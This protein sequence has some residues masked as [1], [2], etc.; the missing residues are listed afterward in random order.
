[1]KSK[2]IPMRIVLYKHKMKSEVLK[3]MNYLDKQKIISNSINVIDMLASPVT[4]ERIGRT[5]QTVIAELLLDG[6]LSSINW[7]SK[8][9]LKEMNSLQGV[10]MLEKLVGAKIYDNLDE[11]I[12]EIFTPLEKHYGIYNY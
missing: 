3:L 7:F 9:Q 10:Q 12:D 2:N 4:R 11:F 6:K 5:V 8:D 1:M